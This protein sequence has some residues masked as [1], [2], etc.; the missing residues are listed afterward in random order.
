MRLNFFLQKCR[1]WQIYANSSFEIIQWF[2]AII[3]VISRQFQVKGNNSEVFLIVPK[4][5]TS[6]AG[7]LDLPKRSYKM[8]PLY[9]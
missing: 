4:Y 6:E 8:L 9:Q 5:K 1:S 2:P 3:P 7:N